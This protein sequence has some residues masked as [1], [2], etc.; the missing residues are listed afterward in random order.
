MRP[1]SRACHAI[2]VRTHADL[3]VLMPET[4]LLELG[5]PLS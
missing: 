5:W 2:D 4:T 1:L 3:C